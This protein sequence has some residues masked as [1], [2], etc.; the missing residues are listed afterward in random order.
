M[1]RGVTMLR[2]Q[3]FD[4]SGL[5]FARTGTRSADELKGHVLRFVDVRGKKDTD[6][7]VLLPCIRERCSTIG[8]V[9]RVARSFIDQSA[10]EW[11]VLG[12]FLL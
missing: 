8:E 2:R 7:T 12:A 5:S 9:D 3:V 4:P 11:P 10:A 6:V 1:I